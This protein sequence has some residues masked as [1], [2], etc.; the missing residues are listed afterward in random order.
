M[1]N[2]KL[3]KAHMTLKDVTN[4]KLSDA[5]RLSLSTTIDRVN[6]RS[7]FRASEIQTCI[8]LLELNAQ[9]VLNIFFAND[10]P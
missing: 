2:T 6:G 3:F 9:D 1:L 4:V 10:V 8:K 7:E 5:L